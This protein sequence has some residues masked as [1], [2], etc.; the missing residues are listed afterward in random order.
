MTTSFPNDTPSYFADAESSFDESDI[1]IFGV[2][3]DKTASFR[4]GARFGPDAIRKASWNFESFN[5]HT[6]VDLQDK[7]IHDYGNLNFDAD[8]DVNYVIEK[9]QSF[10]HSIIEKDKIPVLLGG[11]HSLS[12][13]VVQSFAKNIG[14]LCFDAH[15]DF[16]NKYQDER[17]NHACTLRR[18]TDHVGNENIFLCGLRS[19]GKEEYDDLKNYDISCIDT[20]TFHELSIKKIIEQITSSFYNQPIYLTIDIDVFDPAF[21]PGTGTPEPFGL[22]PIDV[23]PIIDA[24]SPQIIGF[25]IMEVNPHFDHGETAFLGAKLTRHILERIS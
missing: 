12:A 15:A 21:A 19:A 22:N 14:V 8:A 9:V 7:Q 6:G 18:M 1:V 20:Y 13:A 16:R 2:C 4:S 11:E 24:L 10:A 5:F 23:L 25:D 3:F 17:Y